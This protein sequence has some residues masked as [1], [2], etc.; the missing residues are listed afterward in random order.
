MFDVGFW[1]LIVIMIVALLVVGPERLPRL[2]RTIGLWVGKAQGFVRTV[3]ADIDR[4]LAT[5]ELR[6]TLAK[7]AQI[8]E[9]QELV[10]EVKT[11]KP[12]EQ[13]A[14]PAQEPQPSVMAA[15]TN[16]TPAAPSS[17]TTSDKPHDGTT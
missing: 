4:E 7:Q 13:T 17:S 8:P 3:K 5:E 2:A 10:D 9:L 1:E 14:A 11:G 6:R 12:T 15:P 16:Q